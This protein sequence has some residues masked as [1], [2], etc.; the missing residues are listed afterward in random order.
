MSVLKKAIEESLAATRALEAFEERVQ[1]AADIICRC[2][3]SGHKV[4][5]CGNGG[6]AAD[7]THLA[8]EIL[9]RFIED[10][11]PYPR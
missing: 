10:R 11:R 4:L 5:V 1:R 2:L 9:C 8:T 7:S 6:S 3:N